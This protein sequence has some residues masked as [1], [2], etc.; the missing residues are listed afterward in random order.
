[1]RG[2]LVQYWTERLDRFELKCNTDERRGT[3][4]GDNPKLNSTTFAL[5]C[6]SAHN[7]AVVYCSGENRCVNYDYSPN[8]ICLLQRFAADS[9]PGPYISVEK[10]SL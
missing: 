1:M 9:V 8:A 3:S 4:R 2:V 6:Y 10:H 5:A 7:H